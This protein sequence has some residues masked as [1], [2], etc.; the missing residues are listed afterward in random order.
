MGLFITITA[1]CSGA[2]DLRRNLL[3]I[4]AFKDR[5]ALALS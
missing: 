5:T 2:L 1:V 4:N 3:Y